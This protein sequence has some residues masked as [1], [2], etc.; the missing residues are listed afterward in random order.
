MAKG[1]P[2]KKNR[3]LKVVELKDKKKMTFENIAKMLQISK[4][5]AFQ[6]YTKTKN[7][8]KG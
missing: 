1:T 6:I 5:R 3:N 4:A 2:A 7:K 8:A